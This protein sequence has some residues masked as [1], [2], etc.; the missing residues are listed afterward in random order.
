MSTP[1]LSRRPLRRVINP[2][3]RCDQQAGHTANIPATTGQTDLSSR[4]RG[5]CCGARGAGL[6]GCNVRA[7]TFM[8]EDRALKCLDDLIS[9]LGVRLDESDSHR[10]YFEEFLP[11]VVRGQANLIQR[12][13]AVIQDLKQ[14]LSTDEWLAL[15]DLYLARVRGEDVALSLD[16]AT[17][18]ER[19]DA[20]R[21]R[22]E[23][24]QRA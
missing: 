12:E 15:P 24:A 9:L 13:A 22:E 21:K 18:R 1:A 23:E 16:V 6:D 17:R 5:G 7:S 11:E 10:Y 3:Y 19:E 4:N 20:R 2:L 14:L 8:T